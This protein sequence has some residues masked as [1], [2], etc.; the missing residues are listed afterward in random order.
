MYNFITYDN[1]NISK[2]NLQVP[3]Q[4]ILFSHSYLMFRVAKEYPFAVHEFCSMKNTILS[5]KLQ[6]QKEKG[7]KEAMF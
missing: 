3:S 2:K 5:L 4:M 7:M 1:L 6:K